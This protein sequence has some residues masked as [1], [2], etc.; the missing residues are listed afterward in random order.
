MK[1]MIPLTLALAGCLAVLSGCGEQKT[2]TDAAAPSGVNPAIPQVAH[3]GSGK[4]LHD[5]NCIS[6][7]DSGKYTSPDHK[8]KNFNQLANQVR[9][10]DA[11]LGV[12]LFDDDIDKIVNYLNDTY[13]KFGK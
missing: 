2:A 10:C 12:K 4:E 6:C 11:N 8:M 1:N 13:Y 7:H 3:G 5:A 9:S